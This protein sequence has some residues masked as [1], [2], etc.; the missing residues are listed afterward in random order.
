MYLKSEMCPVLI[1]ILIRPLA[2]GFASAGHV[3]AVPAVVA[4]RVHPGVQG[5]LPGPERCLQPQHDGER[6]LWRGRW[7]L[8]RAWRHSHRG[9]ARRRGRRRDGIDGCSQERERQRRQLGL[10]SRHHLRARSQLSADGYVFF[11]GERLCVKLE[12][13]LETF[14]PQRKNWLGRDSS[15]LVSHYHNRL[16]K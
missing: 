3:P 7:V 4:P 8:P 13:K 1:R 12:E 9:T 15:W 5:Q 16:Y 6:L 14:L 10:L 11:G 2:G